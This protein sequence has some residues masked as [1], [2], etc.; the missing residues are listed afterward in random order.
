MGGAVLV[1]F[2]FLL[3]N[4]EKQLAQLELQL[5]RTEKDLYMRDQELKACKGNKNKT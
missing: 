2:P 5:K 3:E 1:S 4:R